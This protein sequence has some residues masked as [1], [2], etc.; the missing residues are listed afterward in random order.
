[1][2]SM[3]EHQQILAKAADNSQVEMQ[4]NKEQKIYSEQHQVQDSEHKNQEEEASKSDVDEQKVDEETDDNNDKE[5]K[6]DEEDHNVEDKGNKEDK[7][8]GKVVHEDVK[9]EQ[10]LDTTKSK[11]KDDVDRRK[12]KRHLQPSAHL[13]SPFIE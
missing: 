3:P 4:V 11:N 13:R 1:M 9:K 5:N 12:E 2:D 7:G 8:K 6:V 10:E